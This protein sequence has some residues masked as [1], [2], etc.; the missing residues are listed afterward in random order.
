MSYQVIL[1]SQS[2]QRQL[3]LTGLGISFESVPAHLD[4]KQI[5]AASPELRAQA[6][7]S[8]KADAIATRYPEAIIIAGDTFVVLDG[9]SLEK[10]QDK[11]EARQML[12]FQSG[13]TIT[14]VSGFCY[15]DPHQNIRHSSHQ[16]M[17]ATMRDLSTAEIDR[18][19]KTQP[20]TSWSG[21]FSPSYHEG[22]AFFTDIHGSYS[23]FVYGLPVDELVPL[24]RK[25]K[26]LS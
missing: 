22:A 25:S 24:L 2:P 19:V 23:V 7:A 5:I 1:A 9:K 15:F 26:I 20:V 16:V 21:S 13:R 3:L 18:Y 17:S 6:V 14:V 11:A 12:Q 4:E 10:P 8:A